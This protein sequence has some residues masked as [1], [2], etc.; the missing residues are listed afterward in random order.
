MPTGDLI[1]WKVGN[2]Y[3]VETFWNLDLVLHKIRSHHDMGNFISLSSQ[4]QYLI[5][6]IKSLDCEYHLKNS[7]IVRYVVQN[8]DLGNWPPDLTPLDF[9]PR[10]LCWIKQ[11]ADIDLKIVANLNQFGNIGKICKNQKSY[12]FSAGVIWFIGWQHRKQFC[13]EPCTWQLT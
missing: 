3:D 4:V 1:W 2:R 10:H 7:L 9:F 6:N 11:P 12:I 8:C 5:L 13:W